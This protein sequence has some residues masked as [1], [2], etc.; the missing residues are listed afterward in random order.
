MMS[1]AQSIA[2]IIEIFIL[3]KWPVNQGIPANRSYCLIKEVH[4]NR[5]MDYILL[6]AAPTTQRKRLQMRGGATLRWKKERFPEI[7]N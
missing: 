6:N 3:Y 2:V 5:T 4:N 1:D 7:L